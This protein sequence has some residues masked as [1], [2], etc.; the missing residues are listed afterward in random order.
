[1]GVGD[2]WDTSYDPSNTTKKNR[3][4]GK[5]SW[6][7]DLS[8]EH[9]W[10]DKEEYKGYGRF[11]AEG[12]GCINTGCDNGLTEAQCILPNELSITLVQDEHGRVSARNGLASRGDVWHLKYSNGAWRGKKCC[13]NNGDMDMNGT[14]VNRAEVYPRPWG[15]SDRS[16]NREI[17]E[18]ATLPHGANAVTV[19]MLVP[20]FCD[21]C[22]VST[23]PN[24][25]ESTCSYKHN[26]YPKSQDFEPDEYNPSKR[27]AS[28]KRPVFGEWSYDAALQ[29]EGSWPRHGEELYL[30]SAEWGGDHSTQASTDV[31]FKTIPAVYDDEGNLVTS[32]I[33][34]VTAIEDSLHGKNDLSFSSLARYGDGSLVAHNEEGDFNGRSGKAAPQ[35]FEVQS[36]P[37]HK[38]E[39]T[40]VTQCVPDGLTPVRKI[41]YCQ[42]SLTKEEL[43]G[44]RGG[45]TDFCTRDIKYTH[46]YAH[47]VET[48]TTNATADRK[49]ACDKSEDHTWISID[50]IITECESGYDS[51]GSS[52]G[53]EW[54]G[55]QSG[56][57]KRGSCKGFETGD[58]VG[59]I[60]NYDDCKVDDVNNHFLG[61]QWVTWEHEPHSCCGGLMIGEDHPSHTPQVSGG[62]QQ[63]RKNHTC[64][65]PYRELTLSPSA[66]TG[67]EAPLTESGCTA[68]QNQAERVQI[69]GDRESYWTVHL[70]DCGFWNPCFDDKGN[71]NKSLYGPNKLGCGE[72]LVLYFPLDQFVNCSNFNLTLKSG[73]N[74]IMSG[75][76]EVDPSWVDKMGDYF[77]NA[78]GFF[79]GSP[80]KAGPTDWCGGADGGGPSTQLEGRANIGGNHA[81]FSDPD[82]GV[83]NCQSYVYQE[84]G[85]HFAH[86]RNPRGHM[87]LRGLNLRP[88]PFKATEKIQNS[89]KAY[90]QANN[91]QMYW[92][93]CVGKK[94]NARAKLFMNMGYEFWF[95]NDFIRYDEF[96]DHHPPQTVCDDVSQKV[97]NWVDT[98][99]GGFR[100]KHCGV[101]G[102]PL[103]AA[104]DHNQS[105]EKGCPDCDILRSEGSCDSAAAKCTNADGTFY[106]VSSDAAGKA[107]CEDANGTYKECCEWDESCTDLVIV[108]F[109]DYLMGVACREQVKEGNCYCV[110]DNLQGDITST[111]TRTLKDDCVSTATGGWNAC[112]WVGDLVDADVT[113]IEECANANGAFGDHRGSMEPVPPLYK[114]ASDQAE[115][116]KPQ[117]EGGAGGSWSESCSFISMDKGCGDSSLVPQS[118]I[119]ITLDK[120]LVAPNKVEETNSGYPSGNSLEYWTKTGLY[121]KGE[122]ASFVND[123]CVGVGRYSSIQDASN[124]QPVTITSRKHRLR[125]LDKVWPFGIMGNFS[126]NVMT[127]RDWMET[128]WESKK[129]KECNDDKCDNVMWPT[130]ICPYN[131]DGTCPSKFIGCDGMVIKGKQPDPAPFFVIKNVTPDTF[132]LFTCNDKPID[133]RINQFENMPELERLG[134]D[135]GDPSCLMGVMETE[136][137]A[138]QYELTIN[139]KP[140]KEATAADIHAAGGWYPIITAIPEVCI[141]LE[142]WKE[143]KKNGKRLSSQELNDPDVCQVDD[144]NTAI[145]DDGPH[146][147][148]SGGIIFADDP[149]TI[150]IVEGGGEKVCKRY[151]QCLSIKGSSI[152]DSKPSHSLTKEACTELTK[153]YKEYDPSKGKDSPKSTYCT[154][155]D[156]NCY[157]D[158]RNIFSGVTDINGC[159]A[160]NGSWEEKFTAVDKDENSCNG[161]Q[162]HG[163]RHRK[164][165]W[166]T[167]DLHECADREGSDFSNCFFPHQWGESTM[168]IG[169]GSTAFQNWKVCPHTGDFM[170]YQEDPGV[171]IGYMGHLNDQEI[172]DLFVDGWD[173]AG[174]KDEK[175]ANHWYAQVEQKGTCPICCDHF[176]PHSLTAT[177]TSMPTEWLNLIGC[178]TD[179]CD[180]SLTN[181][182]GDGFCCESNCQACDLGDIYGCEAKPSD[183]GDCVVEGRSVMV[184]TKKGC[185]D[186]KGIFTPVAKAE[187]CDKWV[188]QRF[189]HGGVTNCKKCSKVYRDT[190]PG[191]TKYEAK[192]KTAADFPETADLEGG[193]CCPNCDCLINDQDKSAKGCTNVSYLECEEVIECIGVCSDVTL[194]DVHNV[195]HVKATCKFYPDPNCS[196]AAT[197][198]QTKSESDCTDCCTWEESSG[199]C[200]RAIGE[201]P[202]CAT[203]CRDADGDRILSNGNMIFDEPTCTAAGGTIQ[204]GII[205]GAT[206]TTCLGDPPGPPPDGNGLGLW[207]T[208]KCVP[209]LEAGTYAW[210]FDPCNCF[211]RNVPL[212]CGGDDE[213]CDTWGSCEADGLAT[214][215]GEGCYDNTAGCRVPGSNPIIWVPTGTPPTSGKRKDGAKKADCEALNT[216]ANPT[217]WWAGGLGCGAR[218]ITADFDSSCYDLCGSQQ[219]GGADLNCPGFGSIDLKLEYNGVMWHSD[220]TLMNSVGTHQCHKYDHTKN[221]T[222]D[223]WACINPSGYVSF[224]KL[225]GTGNC[226]ELSDPDAVVACLKAA[227]VATTFEGIPSKVVESALIKPARNSDCNGCWHAGWDGFSGKIIEPS[228]T[229]NDGYFMRAVLGCGGSVPAYEAAMG[230]SQLDAG[231]NV[232]DYY[233][234]NQMHLFMEITNCSYWDRAD[235][236][237]DNPNGYKLANPP[238]YP[239]GRSGPGCWDAKAV[240][241]E[242]ANEPITGKRHKYAAGG[243]EG[244]VM[245]DGAVS[246]C[247]ECCEY[248]GPSVASGDRLIHGA[249]LCSSGSDIKHECQSTGFELLPTKPAESF[250]VV[251]VKDVQKDGSGTLVV[252]SHPPTPGGL[253]C[254]Y[255]AGTPVSIGMADKFEAETRSN[256]TWFGSGSGKTKNRNSANPNLPTPATTLTEGI[257]NGNPTWKSAR[258]LEPYMEIK[259]AD[260][261]RLISK[262]QRYNRNLK[263]WDRSGAG[264]HD[265]GQMDGLQPKNIP[266]P[267]GISPW[268]VDTMADNRGGSFPGNL[269]TR[270]LESLAPDV[271]G[272]S[273]SPGRSG[274]HQTADILNKYSE[275]SEV[276]MGG[277]MTTPMPKHDV[278]ELAGITNYNNI[279]AEPLGKDGYCL[280]PAYTYKGSAACVNSGSKWVPDFLFTKITTFQDHDLSDGEKIHISGSIMYKATCKGVVLGQC[281]SL[282]DITQLT[283]HKTEQTCS[284]GKCIDLQTGLPAYQNGSPITDEM[285]CSMMN[286]GGGGG[287]GGGAIGGPSHPGYEFVANGK[288]LNFATDDILD[289][290]LCET[291]LDG[292]WVIGIRNDGMQDPYNNQPKSISPGDFETGCPLGCRLNGFYT[293]DACSPPTEENPRG[294]C[295]ECFEV[296]ILNDGQVTVE[297][298]CP[299]HEIDDMHMSRLRGCQNS[300]FIDKDTCRNKGWD[301]YDDHHPLLKTNEFALHSELEFDIHDSSQL[302]TVVTGSS[303]GRGFNVLDHDADVYPFQKCDEPKSFTACDNDPDCYFWALDR[304]GA[305]QSDSGVCV[306]LKSADVTV[307]QSVS[308]A[309]MHG[310]G[311]PFYGQNQGQEPN[312]QKRLCDE[313]SNCAYIMPFDKCLDDSSKAMG[314]CICSAGSTSTTRSNCEPSCVWIPPTVAAPTERECLEDGHKVQFEFVCGMDDQGTIKAAQTPRH[315]EWLGGKSIYDGTPFGIRLPEERTNTQTTPERLYTLSS[316]EAIKLG[317]DGF[318]GIPSNK[319]RGVISAGSAKAAN[320]R[321]QYCFLPKE[322]GRGGGSVLDAKDSTE[323]AKLKGIWRDEGFDKYADNMPY[324]SR[325]AGS[326]DIIVGYPQPLDNCAQG[327]SDNPV[328]M[329]F[330]S[331]FSPKCCNS[332]GP[333][334]FAECGDKCY[335]SYVGPVASSLDWAIGPNHVGD[336]VFR[337]N[338]TE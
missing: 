222:E 52:L 97:R 67:T 83:D 255:P 115:C 307:S 159:L 174:F 182:I 99:E 169:A 276:D 113:S 126:A 272:V 217:E 35:M 90:Y 176:L 110:I 253:H 82:A 74:P 337:I 227:C 247:T 42:N 117:S 123:Q 131:A 17:T 311:I 53:A 230:E 49:K 181:V 15:P 112:V 183:Y 305:G 215:K 144:P 39:T 274:P 120:R 68:I 38:Y 207:V 285:T 299:Y 171:E 322:G 36:E 13:T 149:E 46:E 244:C 330:W 236:Y 81:G 111:K 237:I 192:L 224:E 41:P 135:Q 269:A 50:D 133:G 270:D 338:I 185:Q 64:F 289:E 262:N 43:K 29:G 290:Y 292:E 208:G 87:K 287:G 12:C 301:W 326:F 165:E 259:V 152:S 21:P 163:G 233:R 203:M 63:T 28:N 7:P 19:E 155:D 61:Y 3:A 119:D 235:A 258:G 263:D 198:C 96:G 14:S 234:N 314:E 190:T 151:G 121:P 225:T 251:Y 6:G 273:T 201:E 250:N 164:L 240:T 91:D 139:G 54:L 195:G 213:V 157:D 281:W 9:S 20:P 106:E 321:S 246:P 187:D 331:T 313:S 76:S 308:I 332:R 140:Y 310:H 199:H 312:L 108:N 191:M 226:S 264:L 125:D 204:S 25:K 180:P 142:T 309:D 303:R 130:A 277:G 268:P 197:E 101:N 80:E 37:Q 40:Y 26:K 153:V 327:N 34:K 243:T 265:L 84:S 66:I 32:A 256:Q 143:V 300:S 254:A 239:E 280:D 334:E 23:L 78:A 219:E 261:S 212:S 194:G 328:N 94:I 275:M 336:A 147:K 55:H 231:L 56:C 293:P 104:W 214:G 206:A 4:S 160:V 77:G 221:C 124:S 22:K 65:T 158:N 72:E 95:E 79:P 60:D 69:L 132:D 48:G 57:E 31:D 242:F 8:D 209:S 5:V 284:E 58:V 294:R 260:V 249:L 223:H 51:A 202:D 179:P 10:E 156:S 33:T 320:T 238:I 282:K 177:V 167:G 323:C 11:C 316:G 319:F 86:V 141:D 145:R 92:E 211:P 175:R 148:V 122:L 134:C 252:N 184:F 118:L 150:G 102:G 127:T 73:G 138:Q 59:S 146:R 283:P 297:T 168:D 173:T 266:S 218:E 2:P 162:E 128:Q 186:K 18:G 220:W 329:E 75:W 109:E 193:D 271:L 291:V 62:G 306:Y 105:P 93:R 200:C 196:S 154:R 229:K 170:K 325:H 228:V 178:G 267:Y 318:I 304:K 166:K 100:G 248:R 44:V 288:W 296:E 302:R 114:P 24:N 116:E 210:S 103:W 286:G 89:A 1:M 30:S 71:A 85:A 172:I 70:R 315:C 295:F 45:K 216:Q 16:G 279:Y 278:R 232:G 298:L 107:A 333:I 317:G 27:K 136:L 88:Q 47:C 335:D 245:S 161:T 324:W 205:A 129:Y 188:R 137:E 257:A 98:H 241:E 189:A